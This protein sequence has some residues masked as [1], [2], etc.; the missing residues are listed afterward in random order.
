MFPHT[1]GSSKE[2]DSANSIGNQLKPRDLQLLAERTKWHICVTVGQ[3]I[4]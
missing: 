3:V 2:D 4:R 1:R